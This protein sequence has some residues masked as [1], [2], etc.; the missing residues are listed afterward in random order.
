MLISDLITSNNQLLDSFL[1]GLSVYLKK[2]D[3]EL[4]KVKFID[5][6]TDEYVH[7]IDGWFERLAVF[8]DY[9]IKND[10]Y[11]TKLA[12][13]L[14]DAKTLI[15]KIPIVVPKLLLADLATARGFPIKVRVT[16]GK[17]QN[18]IG[19]IHGKKLFL[20]YHPITNAVVEVNLMS[21]KSLE[22]VHNNT[23]L[24]IEIRPFDYQITDILDNIIEP[25]DVIIFDRQTLRYGIYI[26]F[27]LITHKHIVDMPYNNQLHRQLIALGG[28]IINLSKDPDKIIKQKFM[29]MK[30][31]QTT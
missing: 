4:L 8:I 22:L 27:D 31:E 10:K 29:M 2:N 18:S 7:E 3:I 20:G 23:N 14:I 28:S 26:G 1:P 21:P 11:R 16:K 25:G 15:K 17:Y 30:L 24:R 19:V 5:D 9:K 6:A 12:F 13:H